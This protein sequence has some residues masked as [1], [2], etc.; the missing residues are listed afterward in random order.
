MKKYSTVA[1]QSAMTLEVEKSSFVG[2]AFPLK[3]EEEAAEFLKNTQI[4]YPGANHYAYA[5]VFGVDR[6]IQRFSDDGEPSGTAGLPILELLKHRF[7][8]NTMVIVLRYFGGIKLGTGGLKRAYSHTAMG[9]IQAAGIITL[10]LCSV[11]V[12]SCPYHYWGKVQYELENKD[13]LMDEVEYGEVVKLRLVVPFDYEELILR[14]LDDISS[15]QI[16]MNQ[17]STEYRY[18]KSLMD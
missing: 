8:D 7:L 3:H 1:R 5:Y 2:I 15:S 16:I 14:C 4:K 6:Q 9:A 11:Y 10:T 12:V 17:Q 18:I 13:V